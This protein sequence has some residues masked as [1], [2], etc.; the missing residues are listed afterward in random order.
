[1]TPYKQIAEM[2][3]TAVEDVRAFMRNAH[4]K[5]SELRW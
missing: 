4:C 5:R 3:G 2:T 1:M